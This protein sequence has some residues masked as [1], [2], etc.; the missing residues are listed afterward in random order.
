[1]ANVG[2]YT[3]GKSGAENSM[4]NAAPH[5]LHCE[6]GPDDAAV[7]GLSR[8]GAKDAAP[9]RGVGGGINEFGCKLEARS[10][11]E[12]QVRPRLP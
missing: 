3:V 6:V 12:R 10:V 2:E 5:S 11:L 9:D 8:R 1:M 7:D 4:R